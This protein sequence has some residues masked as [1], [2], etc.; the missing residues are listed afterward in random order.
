MTKINSTKSNS[1]LTAIY[2]NDSIK[3][4]TAKQAAAKLQAYYSGKDSDI[5]PGLKQELDNFLDKYRNDDLVILKN[6]IQNGASSQEIKNKQKQA[7]DFKANVKAS[8]GM[9][10]NE[11]KQKQKEILSLYQGDTIVWECRDEN[12]KGH[13]RNLTIEEKLE[14]LGPYYQ[15]QYAKAQAAIDELQPQLDKILGSGSKFGV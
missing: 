6:V 13:Y 15:E 7:K 1:E 11:A 14:K 10:Y 8:N 2:N 9:T 3:T 12:D 5:D 4:D